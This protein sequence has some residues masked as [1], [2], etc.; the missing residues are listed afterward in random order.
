[1]RTFSRTSQFEEDV[2]HVSKRGKNLA[3]LKAVM[4][5][6]IA[7]RS[8]TVHLKDHPLRGEFAGS[9]DCHVEADCFSDQNVQPLNC[10]EDSGLPENGGHPGPTRHS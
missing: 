5:L 9:R 2:K 10:R 4:E 7:G 3:R 8:L 1:M 6:L